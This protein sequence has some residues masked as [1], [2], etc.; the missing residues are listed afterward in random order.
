ML[1][2]HYRL[3]V[4]SQ[5]L[6]CLL[7]CGGQTKY[8]AMGSCW[9]LG[10]YHV[11][12]AYHVIADAIVVDGKRE[13][14]I[15]SDRISTTSDVRLY[16]SPDDHSVPIREFVE[17][18]GSTFVDKR[19][20]IRAEVIAIDTTQDLALLRTVGENE[21]DGKAP[22]AP[23]RDVKLNVAQDVQNGEPCH[24]IGHYPQMIYGQR[25][26]NE[27][28]LWDFRFGSVDRV[29]S[30][31]ADNP[32][33]ENDTAS[34]S[35]KAACEG[36]SAK[37]FTDLYVATRKAVGFLSYDSTSSAKPPRVTG[38]QVVITPGAP[39]GFSGA[40]VVNADG[41][42]IGVYILTR[43]GDCTGSATHANGL[44]T[45]LASVAEQYMNEMQ[46]NAPVK[47]AVRTNEFGVIESNVPNPVADSANGEDL[48]MLAWVRLVDLGRA[49]KPAIEKRLPQVIDQFNDIERQKRA[50]AA[51]TVDGGPP[52][53]EP[54][55]PLHG[56]WH[57]LQWTRQ[58][59]QTASAMASR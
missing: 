20:S 28:V 48:A 53:W 34:S 57:K 21:V 47:P 19:S 3:F 11:V 32:L 12:T 52:I 13:G 24:V 58:Y 16:F 56:P 8:P 2:H 33:T 1:K 43:Y 29:E 54:A 37:K 18:Q 10:E 59:L 15:L 35:T 9:F 25:K 41:D 55:H 6:V 39:E 27:T 45:F 23:K 40:P 44:R 36:A 38:K 7:G 4:V 51:R 22:Y 17:Q 26:W 5:A 50:L 42:V 14:L 30:Y 46:K 31:R 49:V